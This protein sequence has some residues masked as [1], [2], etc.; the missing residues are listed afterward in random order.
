MTKGM[1]YCFINVELGGHK[2]RVGKCM[3]VCM[4]ACLHI[5]FYLFQQ[6][7]KSRNGFEASCFL[8]ES[9]VDLFQ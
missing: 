5:P 3:Y 6:S 8:F 1:T 2:G 4:D 7:K 9:C